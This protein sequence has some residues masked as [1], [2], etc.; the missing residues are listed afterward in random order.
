MTQRRRS[1]KRSKSKSPLQPELAALKKAKATSEPISGIELDTILDDSECESRC[2]I[3][4]IAGL[5]T[6]VEMDSE[7]TAVKT[8]NVVCS[9]AGAVNTTTS[10]T[11][12]AATMIS[13]T[14]T[15]VVTNVTSTSISNV[16]SLSS[17]AGLNSSLPSPPPPPP[18]P[19][20]S[21]LPPGMVGNFTPVARQESPPSPIAYYQGA[22]MSYPG[23]LGPP[24]SDSP[25]MP[26][27]GMAPSL[28]LSISDEDV[29]RIALKLKSILSSEIES[30]VK[31]KVAE[32]MAPLKEEISELR[33]FRSE[34][35]NEVISL[36]MKVDDQ[37]QYSR[38][39]CIRVAGINE[40]NGEDTNKLVLDLATQ[41]SVPL[42]SEDIDR[43]HRVGNVRVG[44]NQR[45]RELIVKFTNYTARLN[46]IKGRKRLRE[47]GTNV[48]ISEDLTKLRKNMYYE[49]RQLV[50]AKV[51][52]TTFSVDGN[53]F[54]IDSNDKKMRVRSTSDLA[55]FQAQPQPQPAGSEGMVS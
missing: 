3:S 25:I 18:M 50:K 8:V 19:Y 26:Y 41:M 38:R 55:L 20:T 47:L 48:Y 43:S 16:S 45:S 14:S 7:N 40:T 52:K 21:V 28:S 24:I 54:I 51:I 33:K 9:A 12:T 30:L 44:R 37:E 53:I 23:H 17:N 27:P 42:K 31:Q 39:M 35:I 11:S 4:S 6:D 32:E 29:T 34:T 2:S 13:T 22:M 36:K 49:C 10:T 1:K 5:E 46:F 15:V